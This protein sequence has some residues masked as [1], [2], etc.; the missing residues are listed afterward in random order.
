MLLQCTS[1]YGH[2]G[3]RFSNCLAYYQKGFERV[4]VIVPVITYEHV[5]QLHKQIK[6]QLKAVLTSFAHDI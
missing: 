1:N 4:P 2:V 5:S 6:Q 3:H